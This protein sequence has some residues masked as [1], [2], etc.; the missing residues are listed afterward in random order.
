[1]LDK[2]RQNLCTLPDVAADVKAK[3]AGTLQWVGMSDI[4]MPLCLNADTDI[5]A[6][7][8]RIRA[9]VSLDDE[10]QRGIHMSRL[11]LACDE[12]FSHESIDFTSLAKLTQIF[13]DTHTELSHNALIEVDFDALIRR[14]ALVSDNSGWRSYPVTLL[15]VRKKNQVKHIE[16]DF[17]VTYSSTCPCSAALA[18]SLIQ[19]NF[20]QSFTADN[21]D[22]ET[23]LNW[24]GSEQ[25][26]NA[27]PH[28]QRSTA[29]IRTILNTNCTQVPL[30]RYID[31]VENTLKTVVQ[32]AVK[33]EDEQ[34]FARLNGQNLLFCE[35]AARR[36]KHVLER[37]PDIEGFWL[38][39]HHHESLHPH[40]ATA[41]AS[42]D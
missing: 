26:I 24:I 13:L 14:K 7:I 6:T 17:S 34:E 41:E 4:E 11:Y 27:T 33:R 1:M 25:G 8:A 42:S 10:A 5:P 31:I 21:L 15:L 3:V 36:I 23:I 22:Y 35:D 16:L 30:K 32:A 28:A 38:R 37:Q 18:R 19:Q 9:E 20:K 40:D 12:V 29:H 2:T 39:V